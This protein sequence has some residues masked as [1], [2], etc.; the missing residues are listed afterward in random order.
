MLRGVANGML[1]LEKLNYVHK[2]SF[3]SWLFLFI[4]L[5]FIYSIRFWP[6][7]W[8]VGHF[9]SLSFRPNWIKQSVAD[10]GC[11]CTILWRWVEKLISPVVV[12]GVMVMVNYLH[13]P[14]RNGSEFHIHCNWIFLSFYFMRVSPRFVVARSIKSSHQMEEKYTQLLGILVGKLTRC[15]VGWISSLAV[16]LWRGKF[17]PDFARVR[18]PISFWDLSFYDPKLKLQAAA[19]AIATSCCYNI[20]Q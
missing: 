18:Y 19:V 20:I 4:F 10:V 2:V 13:W 3:S 5:F 14:N 16:N 11:L 9:C 17:G 15:V 8:E 12:A 6:T 1:Y 7:T